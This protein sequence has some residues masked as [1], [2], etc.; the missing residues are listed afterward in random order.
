MAERRVLRC[1]AHLEEGRQAH[2]DAQARLEE[3]LSVPHFVAC[4]S[5]LFAGLGRQKDFDELC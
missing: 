4:P 3:V 1:R 5:R 2:R